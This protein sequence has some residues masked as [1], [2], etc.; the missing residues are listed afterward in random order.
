MSDLP[1]AAKIHAHALM[2]LDELEVDLAEMKLRNPT[3]DYSVQTMLHYH[4][5]AMRKAVRFHAYLMDQA[6][7]LTMVNVEAERRE[8][9]AKIE[10]ALRER[11]CV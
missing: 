6:G 4:M 1:P 3:G 9:T 10:Q 7:D 8:I 2:L 5:D 11:H